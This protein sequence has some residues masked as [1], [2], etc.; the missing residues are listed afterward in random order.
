[1]DILSENQEY[2]ISKFLQR[3]DYAAV[4]DILEEE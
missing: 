4:L 3:Y 1:M 2:A